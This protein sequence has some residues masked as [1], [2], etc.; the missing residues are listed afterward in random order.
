MIKYERYELE[1][2]FDL[3]YLESRIEKANFRY[4]AKFCKKFKI[5]GKFVLVDCLIEL[6][7][8]NKNL[9]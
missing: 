4:L 2:Y 5:I 9:T 8:Q 1:G 3:T 7:Y 6:G